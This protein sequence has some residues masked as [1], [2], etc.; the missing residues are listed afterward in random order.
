MNHKLVGFQSEKAAQAVA[1][2]INRQSEPI[3]KLKLIKLLYLAEREFMGKYGQPMFYD[4]FFSLP[5]G[6][7]CSNILDGINGKLDK[8]F[9]SKYVSKNANKVVLVCP[10]TRDD[11]DEISDAELEILN[12]IWESFGWMTSGQIRNHTHKHCPEYVEIKEGRVPI[13]YTELFKVLGA[14]NP[15]FLSEEVEQY[16]KTKA[17]LAD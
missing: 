2:F 8:A 16:R 15:Q 10:V 6:P 11:L 4:E 1:Y 12:I 7:I 17:I 13:Y 14:D 5:H 3:E 9:W